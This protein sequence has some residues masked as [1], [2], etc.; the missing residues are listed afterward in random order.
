MNIKLH[1]A[2]LL[3]VFT[4]LGCN[5]KVAGVP[6]TEEAA[7]DGAKPEAGA[8]GSDPTA[9]SETCTTKG[10]VCLAAGQSAPPNRR[11]ATPEEASCAGGAD[12]WL[13]DG[14][15][16]EVARCSK[17]HECNEDPSVSSIKG[18][19]YHGICV[20]NPGLYVQP[21]GKCGVTP[22]PDC[23]AHGGTCEQAA[24]CAAGKLTSSTS[25]NQSCG[26][27][28]EAV[29][30]IEQTSCIGPLNE[31]KGTMVCCAP[32]NGGDDSVTPPIC[33]NGWKT[34]PPGSKAGQDSCT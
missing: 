7:P 25:T 4:A 24:T 26:G 18:L 1:I 8:P 5:A 14:A 10:G 30:C 34:C 32:D 22:P 28:N 9:S 16:P 20:C 23:A 27:S 17:D 33:V 13:V 29:C 6:A 3:M 21:S 11:K 31:E 2:P 12:C 19:C 15:T